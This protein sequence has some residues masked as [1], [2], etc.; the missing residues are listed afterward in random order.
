VTAPLRLTV[1]SGAGV[2][3]GAELWLLAL[4]RATDRLV[5]DAVVL[6]EGPF[7]EELAALGVPVDVMPTGRG[8][9]VVARA[10]ARLARRLSATRPE[11]LLANGAK[12]AAI[13]APAGIVA[14]VRCVWVK[15]DHSFDGQPIGM[16][17][18]RLVDSVVVPSVTL[19]PTSGHSHAVV[20]M[21]PRAAEPPLP[22]DAARAVLAASGVPV[23]DDRL[24]FAVVGRMVRYKGVE[25]AVLALAR[26]GAEKWR[27][28]VIGDA[29][30]A[31]P[32][33][34]A[35]L[36]RL[37]AAVGVAERVAFTG[38][39]PDAAG[40][41][42]GVD[43][44][45]VL[46][47]PT[48]CGPDREGFG[49]VAT[50]AMIAG[51]PVVAT[52]GGPVVDRLAG[53][54]G[55]S[56][57]PGNP[58]A[59]AAALGRLA[60]PVL[61]AA[62]GAAG[63]ELSA[64]HPDAATCA[65]RLV[66]ELARVACRPGA[67]RRD[68]PPISVVTTVRNEADAVHRLLG[69]LVDQL[70]H[71]DDEI[72]VVDGGSSDATAARVGSWTVREPRVRLLVRPGAGIS[73]G[74]NEGVLAARNA[75]VA[76]T[77]AGCDPAPGWL[78]AF[79]S[80]AADTDS[81]RLYTGV[82]RVRADGPLQMAFAAVGYP[83]LAELRHPSLLARAYGRLLGRCFDPTMP[84]GRSMAFGQEVWRAAHG[85]PE[86]LRTGEDVL[87]G[88]A[89]VAAGTTAVLVGDAEVRWVQRPSAWATARMYYHYGEGSGRS[90][91]P[92]L[93]G[94]DLARLATYA[95]A[96]V[97]LA[98]G[99]RLGRGAALAAGVAYLSLPVVRVLR[100]S[101]RRGGAVTLLAAVAAI[102]AAAVIRDLAKVAGALS[103]LGMGRRT[104]GRQ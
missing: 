4:V 7:A 41:L 32:G 91:D 11:L 1:V 10:V 96:T 50:E 20:V 29:D 84:T 58:A 22:R 76:C 97:A 95:A 71:P 63:A 17:L 73:A 19:A 102:P 21:P 35:R 16:A 89:A 92:R 70:S 15:H 6:D 30:P 13:A 36:S 42:S 40:V 47:K 52:A 57:P 53:R 27:L 12:A 79:R 61:R 39:L 72:V 46:T 48:G 67:G 26:P 104:A 43:A 25:D 80:A 59:V 8:S 82:Y 31:E 86:H 24:L 87:F 74:R 98:R 99:G 88:R 75:L 49:W 81:A 77:D 45:G 14:G 3:G 100:G 62:M 64:G 69:R 38:P 90:R 23:D 44:V 78:A 94:R 85:F 37:A 103:G 65:D 56:V 5:L 9:G 33:E 68:G 18:A 93:L 51:V 34:R 55:I 28:A 66:R 101:T 60:E 83:D 2:L 54:A